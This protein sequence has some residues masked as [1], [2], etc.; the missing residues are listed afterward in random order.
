MPKS[1]SET[2]TD[3]ETGLEQRGEELRATFLEHL[4]ELRTR[5]LRSFIFVTIG[6]II[7]YNLYPYII[8]LVFDPLMRAGRATVVY[9][10][11]AD[12]FMM[13]LKIGMFIG[14]G[15]AAPFITLQLWAFVAPGLTRNE[16]RAARFIGPLSVLLFAIG[17][18]FGMMI[19]P[20]ALRWFLGYLPS[21]AQLMQDPQVYVLF[22]VK[23]MLAF[24]I[25]F[26][27]PIVILFLARI[28]VATPDLLWRYWRQAVVG[29]S[30]V[31]MVLTPSNDA[32]TMITMAIPMVILYFFS[33]ALVGFVG[34]A[35]RKKRRAAE[36][37]TLQS[38]PN[39]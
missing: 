23:M 32:V 16:R 17:V 3:A 24:G 29:I 33:I 7:G 37:P 6:W 4:G 12:A 25:A 22:V 10:N 35:D 1:Q 28:G 19:L 21:D 20:T 15:I 27:L 5:I 36:S 18:G 26:E 31:A 34:R 2:S 11:F 39:A 13:Q 14:L 8:D 30:V 9:R 38:P